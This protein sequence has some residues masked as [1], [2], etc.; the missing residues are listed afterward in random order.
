M[1]T[2]NDIHEAIKTGLASKGVPVDKLDDRARALFPKALE[3]LQSSMKESMEK[4]A[5]PNLQKF[6][7]KAK[8]DLETWVRANT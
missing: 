8:L 5:T 1:K 2:M 7:E 4:N 6:V 3:L